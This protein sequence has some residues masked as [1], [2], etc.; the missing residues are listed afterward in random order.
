MGNADLDDKGYLVVNA[1]S[2][3]PVDKYEC[4]CPTVSKV[5]NGVIIPCEYCYCCWGHFKFRYE[6]ML[7]VKLELT[8]IVSSPHDTDGQ[9]PCVFRYKFI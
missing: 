1:V 2:Y 9:K 3:Y 5:K 4:A 8:E 7:N 6:I